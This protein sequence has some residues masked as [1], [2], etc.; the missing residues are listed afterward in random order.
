MASKISIKLIS[1]SLFFLFF[2]SLY[3]QNDF[4]KGYFIDIYGN[5]VD[6]LIKNLDWKNNPKEFIYKTSENGELKTG[7]LNSVKKFEILDNVIYIK[8]SVRAEIN[9]TKSNK[10]DYS[11]KLD[12]KDEIV[13][14]KL[15]VGG[16]LNLYM[17]NNSNSRLFYFQLENE[18]ITLLEYKEYINSNEQITK[19][20]NYK[21][22]LWS[23][24]QCKAIDINRVN[25][26]DYVQSDLT[27]IFADFNTCDNE[28]SYVFNKKKQGSIIN[29][30]IRPGI[31][32][33][34]T[35]Y[36]SPGQDMGRY[37][38]FDF[39][40]ELSFRLGIEFEYILPFNNNK[41]SLIFEPTY[42]YYKTE[43]T[44][45]TNPRPEIVRIE[46]ATVDYSSIELPLGFR[47]YSYLN[48]NSKLF[49]NALAVLDMSFKSDI[50][51]GTTE[52]ESDT[53]FSLAF[54]LGY[55]YKN[56]YSVEARLYTNRDILNKYAT[57]KSDFSAISLILGYNIF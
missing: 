2:Y 36:N 45:D 53:G 33:S 6:C 14:L 23:L 50:T 25:N 18:P 5:K 43:K 27:S 46:T 4:E 12:L 30:N 34:K 7:D 15:L 22:Q 10:L 47:H 31:N 41:W 26:T 38:D 3:A 35:D 19:N 49:A 9:A 57:L 56:K 40:R 17:Y 54:G 39:D 13:F 37:R 24:M 51:Y 44:F 55:N 42:Q 48:T 20:Q 21:K 8:G 28:L 16:K 29:I 32:F 1:F 11:D 52:L